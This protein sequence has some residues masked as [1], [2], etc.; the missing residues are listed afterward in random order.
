M[1][2]TDDK[3]NVLNVC[4]LYNEGTIANSTSYKLNKRDIGNKISKKDQEL[5]SM[6]TLKNHKYHYN[7]RIFVT[8][9]VE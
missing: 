7:S 8:E 2:F 4:K 3:C 5:L 6:K 1:K 9:S